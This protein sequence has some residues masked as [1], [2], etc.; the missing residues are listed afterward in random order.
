[1]NTSFNSFF[2]IYLVLIFS[3]SSYYLFEKHLNLVEYTISDWLINYQGGFTRRGLL[4]EIVFKINFLFP[5]GLR[6]VIYILQLISYSFYLIL[7]FFFLK[8][9]KKNYFIILAIFS[10]IFILYPLAE[11]EVLARK[12]LF[13]FITFLL[14]INVC[15]LKKNE[16]IKYYFL[17]IALPLIALI[18]EGVIFY[19]TFFIFLVILSN[20]K[21]K[22]INLKIFLSFLPFLITLFFIF[23]LKLSPAG[24][25][26]MCISVNECY[27]AMN[28]TT[29][30]LLFYYNEAT[31]QFE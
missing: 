14:F 18:W 6:K 28:F 7:V 21:N 11:V 8:D 16:N 27:G 29:K 13:L 4:G 20:K 10:P 23:F 2:K 30:T 24:M 15:S 17:S 19:I 25:A 22:L 9:L 31:S 1:M 12:E 26:S 3:L 5:I